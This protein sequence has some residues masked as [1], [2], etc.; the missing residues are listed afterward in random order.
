VT[1]AFPLHRYTYQDYV[2][3]E[4][5]STTRHE[6]LAGEIV[7][8]AGGTP[9]HAAMAAEIIRQL[10]EKLHGS[11]CR[12]FTSDLGVRVMATGLATYPDASVVCGPTERDPDKKT[13]IT[14]PKLL[15]EVTSDSTEDYDRGEKLEHYKQIPSLEAVVIVSHRE[16]LIEVWSRDAGTSAWTPSA[17]RS[18]EIRLHALRCS[19]DIDAIHA[20]AQ[21]PV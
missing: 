9:E 10:G 21:E 20:S 17:A 4:E 8:M 19:L 2:W 6:F 16:K 15:V 11:R 13:N 12:V 3:L 18:G 5:E 1:S 14:N 7:A